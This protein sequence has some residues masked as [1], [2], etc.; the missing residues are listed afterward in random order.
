MTFQQ[1]YTDGSALYSV[2]V[3]DEEKSNCSGRD[4]IGYNRGVKHTARGPEPARQG[5]Q[6]GPQDKSE[7]EKLQ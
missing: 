3:R 2:F 7:S 5:V 4:Y 1:W 6:S